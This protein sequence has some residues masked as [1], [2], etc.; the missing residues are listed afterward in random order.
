MENVP[1]SDTSGIDSGSKNVS[2]SDT[3][4]KYP[5]AGDEKQ[6]KLRGGY[7]LAMIDSQIRKYEGYLELLGNDGDLPRLVS[8]YN[9]LLDALGLL[10]ERMAVERECG[11]YE[12]DST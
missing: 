8:E 5:E 6:L 4:N 9:C 7:E 2:E 11:A 3:F 10:R 1:E 12:N